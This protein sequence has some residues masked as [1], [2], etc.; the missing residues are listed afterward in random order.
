MGVGSGPLGP[1]NPVATCWGV[2]TVAGGVAQCGVVQCVPMAA[3]FRAGG[4]GACP[5]S[6]K[7]PLA[8]WFADLSLGAGIAALLTV[9]IKH[10]LCESCALRSYIRKVYT[11]SSLVT[12]QLSVH[13]GV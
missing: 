12:G 10:A 3:T 11:T 8:T 6:R 7:G 1:Q 5:L 4:G 2:Y 9:H 13:T